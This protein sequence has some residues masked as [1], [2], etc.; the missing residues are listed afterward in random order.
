MGPLDIL[1]D[2]VKEL[3]DR[4]KSDFVSDPLFKIDLDLLS[5]NHLIKV[6]NVDFE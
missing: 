3:R 2:L 4:F 1:P 6:Q 5:V